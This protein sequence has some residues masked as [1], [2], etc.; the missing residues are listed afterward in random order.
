MQG[1]SADIWKENV[2]ENLEIRMLEYTIVGVFGRSN[3]RKKI[4]RQQRW[5][6]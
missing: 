4:T 2:S 3:L 6:S 5:Y 1:R